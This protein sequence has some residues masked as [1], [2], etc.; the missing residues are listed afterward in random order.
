MKI[1]THDNYR[2]CEKCINVIDCAAFLYCGKDCDAEYCDQP[3]YD[4]DDDGRLMSCND[5]A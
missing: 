5:L 3:E 2:K 4:F 1:I